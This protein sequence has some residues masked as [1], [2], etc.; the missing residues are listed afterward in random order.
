MIISLPKGEQLQELLSFPTVPTV[1][2]IKPEFLVSCS[3]NIT[4]L[5]F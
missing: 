4:E 3:Y 5:F 1:S 2:N